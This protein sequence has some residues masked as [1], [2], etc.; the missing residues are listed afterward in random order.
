MSISYNVISKFYGL[1]DKIYFKDKQKNPRYILSN[2]IQ[3]NDLYLLEI[4]VG[5]AENIILFAKQNPKLKIIGIDLSEQMLKIAQNK[6]TKDNINN[7]ELIKM[8]ATNMT[9][10]NKTFDYI[11]I[12]LLLHELKE[13]ISNKILNQC[14]KILKNN[15]KIYVIEWNYP[16]KLSQKIKFS[17]INFL[18]PFANKDFRQFMKKDFHEYFSKNGFQIKGIEYGDYTKIM[19]L[20]KS[21]T[22]T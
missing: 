10:D 7:V 12:S 6:I 5:T 8:D 22:S 15:G 18:E 13:E 19:E 20:E 17:M 21:A 9:F 2:K 3:N 16:K 11:I 4:A 1:L 14:L